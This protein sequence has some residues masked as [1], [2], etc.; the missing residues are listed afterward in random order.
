MSKPSYLKLAGRGQLEQR[1]KQALSLLTQCH[2]C[3]RACGVDRLA[4]ETGLCRTA[5]KARVASFH[6]HFGE[7]PPLVGRHG[8]GT[9]FFSGC[10]LL[11]SFCQNYEISHG[12]EGAETAPEELAGMML[13]LA[14]RGCHNINF[15]TP[16]HVVPQ[17]LEALPRAIEQGLNIPL[18]YNSG[19]YDN[20]ETLRLLDGIFDIYMPDFKFWDEKWAQRYCR[21]SDYREKA[22]AALKEMHRQVGNLQFDADG[23]AFHGLLVRHLVMP[24][25]VAGSAPIME[26][27]ARELSPETYLNIM[28]QYHPCGAARRDQFINRRVSAEEMAQAIRAARQSGLLRR[29]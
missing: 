6:A 12:N 4:G 11:C 9:I 27:L 29:T 23:L 22:M 13:E 8:S 26:F 25:G 17:I 19:G 1:L 21:A 16:T 28:A 20:V 15:V 10:N 7:E 3:P 2:L 14:A 5:R 18:V 24:N